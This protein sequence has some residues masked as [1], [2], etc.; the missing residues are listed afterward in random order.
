MSGLLNHS[1]ALIVANYLV[2]SGLASGPGPGGSWPVFVN[3]EPDVPDECITV[4]DADGRLEG[5]THVDGEMQEHAGIQVRVRVAPHRIV[6]GYQKTKTILRNFD[7]QVL[8]T[9]VTIGSNTYK[10]QAITR[11]SDVIPL[12]DESPT[13]RR[14]VQVAN[15]LVSLTQLPGTGSY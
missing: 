11:Q 7:T 4:Y 2:D 6:E 8:R 15:A 5:R 3:K 13:S 10:I 9:L 1:P 14:Y 12:G